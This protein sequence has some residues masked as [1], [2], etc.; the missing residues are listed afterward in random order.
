MNITNAVNLTVEINYHT[1]PER[2]II[3]YINNGKKCLTNHLKKLKIMILNII[4]LDSQDKIIS[5]YMNKNSDL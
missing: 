5:R 2:E 4:F 1:L 3:E